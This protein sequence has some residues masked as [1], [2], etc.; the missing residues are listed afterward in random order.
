MNWTEEQVRE[1]EQRFRGGDGDVTRKGS[2]NHKLSHNSVNAAPVASTAGAKKSRGMN[3]L[4]TAFSYE[5]EAQKQ[6]GEIAW[7]GFES[8]RFRLADGAWYKADFIVLYPSGELIVVET[9]GFWRESARLRIKVAAD[10]HPFKFVAMRKK[11]AKDG[12]GWDREEF[13]AML[14]RISK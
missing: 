4:E 14:D 5:L 8:L 2:A 6:A 12:G 9:K 11:K 13:S 10:R 1:A 7:W 3:G